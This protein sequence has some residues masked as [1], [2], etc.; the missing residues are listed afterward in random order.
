[1]GGMPWM[2]FVEYDEDEEP[3]EALEA[4]QDRE[5]DLGRYN[6]VMP[7]PG[8]QLP[9][10]GDDGPGG[11]HDDIDDAREAAE[12]DG[13]R[14][15]LDMDGIGDTRGSGHA[16]KL[17]DKELR[18][19]FKTDRP[20]REQVLA[21]SPAG[22]FGPDFGWFKR[23]KIGRGEGVFFLCYEGDAPRWICFGGVSYD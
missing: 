7:F 10:V 1:M 19:A 2:Y 23:L 21:V 20:S 18:R 12:E 22:S 4:L 3:E 14:S 5:L 8:E 17:S 16:V 9:I 11:E 13:T 6:P 15:I